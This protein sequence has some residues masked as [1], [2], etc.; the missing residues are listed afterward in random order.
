MLG[1][2]A[3]QAQQALRAL[4]VQPERRALLVLK[5]LK[6]ILA[7]KDLRDRRGLRVQPERKVLRAI[8]VKWDPRVQKVKKV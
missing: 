7:N 6:E 5:A 1:P 8:P 2:P 4:R 3:Q